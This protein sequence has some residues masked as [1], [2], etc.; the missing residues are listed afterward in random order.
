MSTFAQALSNES[1]KT[2]TENG[3]TAYNT[4]GHKLLDLFSTIGSLRQRSDMEI[5]RL[6]ADAYNEDALN[7]IKC[8]FYA[9]DIRGGLGERKTFRT[10]LK[11]AANHHPEAVKRNIHLIGEYGRFDDLYCLVGTE[12]E[13]AMFTFVRAQLALDERNMKQNKPVSLLAKWLKTPDASSRETRRLGIHTANAIGDSVYVFK[14]RLR[15]LRKYINIVERQMSL[16]E[17]NEINYQSVPSR[18]MTLYRCAFGRHDQERFAAYLAAV[19]KGEAK[20]NASTLFPYDLVKKYVG[21]GYD[22]LNRYRRKHLTTDAT[23]EAQWKALPNYLSGPANALVMAD[24][25]GSMTTDNCRPLCSSMALAI[26]FAERNTGA[27]HNLWLSFSHEATVQRLRGET[28]AQK[29]DSMDTEHWAMNTNLEAAFQNILNIAIQNHIDP[30]EMV[31]SLIVI[32][33]MEIDAASRGYAWSFYDN[34]EARFR[35]AGYEI[36][37]VV[38]WN[39]NSRHDVFHADATRRGVQLCSG[40]SA[41]T[42]KVLMASIGMTPVEMM[43]SVLNSERYA[44]VTLAS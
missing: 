14:R 25:S 18:A 7:T 27:Y 39:V 32:S 11:Y 13:K 17:W 21:D 36:P 4:T 34:M 41:A 37:N 38:F 1:R 28:L 40:Q 20:I 31:R 19:N 42:F 9:R 8:L 12:L 6:F 5:E 15:A 44:P 33:D 26:Y 30:D 35:R 10:L 23:V 2:F 22:F 16:K 3:A 43:M 29:L 24:V